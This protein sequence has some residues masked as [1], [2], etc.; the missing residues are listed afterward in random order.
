MSIT[1]SCDNCHSLFTVDSRL[2]GRRARCRKCDR[3]MRVPDV[4]IDGGRAGGR[5]SPPSNTGTGNS[6]HQRGGLRPGHAEP[7]AL[8]ARPIGWLDAVNSQVGLKPITI[9]N[10]PVL[11]PRDE[12]FE[13]SVTSYKVA[14]PPE[15][16]PANAVVNKS[17]QLVNA[18]Y[19]ETIR[20]Y[21]QFFK[22]FAY[23]FRRINELSYGFSLV[24]FII[25]I[26]EGIMGNHGATVLCIS[27]IVLLNLVGLAAAVSNVIALQ[28]RGNPVQGIL[29]L[30]PPVTLYYLW[31][32][33]TK[34]K[35]PI[36]RII[37]PIGV[38]AAVIG[39]YTYIPW[40]NGNKVSQAGWK[41]QIE[42]AVDTIKHDVKGSIEKGGEKVD[43]LK[44][45]L[46]DDLK[47][48]DFEKV[49]KKAGET[50]DDLKDKF[51]K[52]TQTGDSSDK[53]AP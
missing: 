47:N 21:K 49:K 29:F 7:S 30:I 1:F 35:R 13:S 33:S 46:P 40:L 36:N 17:K 22:R 45:Q 28:F 39:A 9:F 2:A 27:A 31:S 44:D 12:E 34:W 5:L 15:L 10:A 16:R 51:Q 25:A 23:L 14:V 52:S 53:G 20:T 41:E 37:T 32:N 24:L 19:M 8:A 43:E 18:G 4:S 50:I 11:R 6:R 48:I 3:K 38:L 42:G 26:V